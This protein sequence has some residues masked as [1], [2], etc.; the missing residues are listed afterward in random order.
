MT[1]LHIANS[2]TADMVGELTAMSGEELRFAG[3]GAQR[4][5]WFARDND[6]VV[7]P[8]LPEDVYLDYVTSLT[9]TNRDTL[10]LLAP[11]P[12]VVGED[13]LS[14]DRLAD[15]GFRVELRAA[16]AGRTVDLVAP[17]NYDLA[18]ADL[19]RALGLLD[20]LPGHEFS[21]QGGSAL[22]NS[23]GVFRAIA[24][25]IGAPIAPGA[26]VAER[27]DAVA[28][29]EELLVAGSPVIVKQ[30]HQAGGIGNE[31][32]SRVPGIEPVGARGTVVLPD[33]AAVVDY[34]EREW[35]W[36]T[37]HRRDRVIIEHYYPGSVPVYV[38]FMVTADSIDLL[39]LGQMTMNPMFEGIIA[40]PIALTPAETDEAV[41][42]SRRLCEPYQQMGYRGVLTPDV[43][44]TPGRDLVI[45]EINGRIS[46]A[47]HLNGAIAECLGG[48]DGLR[49]R[50]LVER[51][52]WRVPSFGEA[53]DRLHASDLAIDQVRREGIVLVFDTSRLDGSVRY[54]T[55]G[56]DMDTVRDY[57]QRLQS[58]FVAGRV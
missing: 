55:I 18:A 14:P 44:L 39:G 16:L 25:G 29:V 20:A 41:A 46:G 28:V 38:E 4:M 35:G 13:V 37:G 26:V 32:L 40:P 54:C 50:V 21:A 17:I 12:G 23:K 9:G 51:G 10:T 19:A 42:I 24:A 3:A 45:S 33:R 43:F 15:N 1:T 5:S 53:V 27:R 49:D 7:L 56:P 30:E 34:V 48:P 36:L 2:R 6:I 8:W 22:V 52:G 58:L 11:P 57:E 47:T 31:I